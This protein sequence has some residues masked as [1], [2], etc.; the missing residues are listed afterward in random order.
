[1]FLS[2]EGAVRRVEETK[3]RRRKNGRGRMI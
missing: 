1:V 3:K 2:R